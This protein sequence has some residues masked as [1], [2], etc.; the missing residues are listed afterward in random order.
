MAFYEEISKYYDYIFPVEP[1]QVNL[2][3]EVAKDSGARILD[4]ACGAGGYTEELTK[5]GFHV[6]A[7]DIDSGMVRETRDRMQKLGFVVKVEQGDMTALTE[8]FETGFDCTFCIGN[9][10][11]HLGSLDEIQK[12]LKSM[13]SLLKIGGRLMI[14]IINFDRVLK[15]GVNELPTLIN[16]DVPLEF[17]RKYRR[18]EGR[19]LIAFETTLT[20]KKEG[21]EEQFLNS[22]ELLPLTMEKLKAALANAGFAKMAFY[23][24]F[25][26]T[27]WR[28]DSFLTVALVEK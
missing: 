23:G 14:Q 20:I 28:D 6:E 16:K 15:Y 8:L 10:I 27:L 26:K 19:D 21:A 17:I 1:S 7:V 5:A 2:I 13:H 11:V 18:I 9:S 3:K 24:D 4:V 22:I 12:A 25:N